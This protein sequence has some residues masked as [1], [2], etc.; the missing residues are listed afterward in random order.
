MDSVVELR[1]LESHRNLFSENEDNV[2][3]ENK[4]QRKNYWHVKTR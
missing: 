1:H 2:P 3:G 4:T